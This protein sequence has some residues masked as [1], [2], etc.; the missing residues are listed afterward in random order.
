MK[1][2]LA[3]VAMC[4]AGCSSEEA[5]PA[6]PTDTAG[7]LKTV[8]VHYSVADEKTLLDSGQGICSKLESGSTRDDEIQRLMVVGFSGDQALALVQASSFYL[9]PDH[10]N[11]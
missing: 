8:R 3:I 2:V 9:C 1:I 4:L 11:K 5:K 7:Y 10:K 6:V